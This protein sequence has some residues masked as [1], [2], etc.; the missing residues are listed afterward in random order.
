[1][2]NI[3]SEVGQ[4]ISSRQHGFHHNRSI[5]TDLGSDQWPSG[6]KGQ[7]T[8]VGG[9]IYELFTV[10]IIK[11]PRSEPINH[12][13]PST[14]Y[15]SYQWHLIFP[16]LN[17]L[18]QPSSQKIGGFKNQWIPLKEAIVAVAAFQVSHIWT[19]SYKFLFFS[20]KPW[21]R[22]PDRDRS[23]GNRGNHE[24]GNLTCIQN[25]Y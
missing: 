15:H 25:V 20:R 1:M 14:Q 19:F 8:I 18:T 21:R 17:L 3:D 5:T 6:W 9:L 12:Q 13:Y 16:A 2:I 23:L 11:V 22:G 24:L 4:S 10:S 7:L